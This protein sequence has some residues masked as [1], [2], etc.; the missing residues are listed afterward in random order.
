[1]RLITTIFL[2]TFLSSCLTHCS[3][4]VPS[5]ESKYAEREVVERQ[6]QQVA[7]AFN[8]LSGKVHALEQAAEQAENK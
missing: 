6:L 1:M 3:V 5:I 8:E 2:I 4:T 7:A